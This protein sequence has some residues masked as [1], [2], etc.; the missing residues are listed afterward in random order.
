M[1]AT[2]ILFCDACEAATT[3]SERGWRAYLT[4]GEAGVAALEVLCPL[5]AE[6]VGGEDEAAWSE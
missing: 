3:R 1:H 5:C 6:S 4:D 2:A